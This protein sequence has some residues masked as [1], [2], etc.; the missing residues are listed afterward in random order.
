MS[1][2]V[3]CIWMCYPCTYY[4]WLVSCTNLLEKVSLFLLEL[5]FPCNGGCHYHDSVYNFV[6][7]QHTYRAVVLAHRDTKGRS[8][9]HQSLRSSLTT[10]TISPMQP[11][12]KKDL[13]TKWVFSCVR[14]VW[15]ILWILKDTGLARIDHKSQLIISKNIRSS[16]SSLYCHR[17]TIICVYFIFLI[18]NVSNKM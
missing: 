11:K 1:P 3:C 18:P 14:A 12:Q 6:T 5:P 7:C 4:E 16:N 13:S 10:L 15:W 9:G 8:L 2:V 17:L